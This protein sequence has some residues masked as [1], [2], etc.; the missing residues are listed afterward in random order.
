MK[1]ALVLPLVL[2]VVTGMIPVGTAQEDE[3]EDEPRCIEPPDVEP[4][5]EWAYNLSNDRTRY[6][7]V[8]DADTPATTSRGHH[9]I[10]KLGFEEQTADGE[11]KAWGSQV[12]FAADS[13]YPWALSTQDRW[14]R[15]DEGEL[16]RMDAYDPPFRNVHYTQETCPGQFWE[17]ETHHT[18]R[19]GKYGQA[20]SDQANETWQVR[21]L[22]WSNV[23][24]P[25][26]TFEALEIASVRTADQYRITTHW[27]PEVQGPVKVVQGP[28]GAP[29]STRELSWYILDQRPSPVWCYS[30]ENATC[31]PDAV[32]PTAGDT[33]YLNGSASYDVEGNVTDYTWRVSGE[34]HRG[35]V[36]SLN[37]TEERTLDVRLFVTD[38]AN[39]TST[40]GQTIYVAPEEGTGVGVS[41]PTKALEGQ[42]VTLEAHTSFDPVE[43]RWRD[44]ST[45]VG[46][47]D[48]YQF[49]MEETTNLSV[50]AFHESGRVSTTNHTVHLVDDGE[51]SEGSDEQTQR[52]P[53]GGSERLAILE[54]LEGQVVPSSFEVVVRAETEATLTADDRPVW[55]GTADPSE[56]VP[57]RL[58][59]GDRTLV[60]ASSSEQ[61]TVNVTV[62]ADATGSG[63]EAA[64]TDNASTGDGL[65]PTPAPSALL[66]AGLVASLALARRRER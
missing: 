1:R 14:E 40:L 37:L 19:Y 57:V 20:S 3:G 47:G 50:D 39:R 62:S 12:R 52:Y 5:Y 55:Q 17:F 56:R 49:Y 53:P 46:D 61:Q 54:P 8:V 24:V 25:A 32:H 21:A 13:P 30:V 9:N 11:R 34:V 18:I 15:T 66:V 10:T 38:E 58:D 41:G 23:S 31:G 65:A 51:G 36:A 2:V 33:L 64:T 7:E 4:T 6:V 35:P 27:S 42:V 48:T 63:D 60:L 29:E 26:G 16:R 44:N 43:I 59:Q 45:V 28:G 22:Q